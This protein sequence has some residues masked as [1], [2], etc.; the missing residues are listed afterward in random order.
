[1]L[2]N[3]G[4]KSETEDLPAAFKLMPLYTV[5]FYSTSIFSFIQK[6]LLYYRFLLVTSKKNVIDYLMDD[7]I[8]LK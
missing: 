6:D 8:M 2:A 7:K 5:S 4:N 1:M 3:E